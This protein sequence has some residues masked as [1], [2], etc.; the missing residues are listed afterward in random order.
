MFSEVDVPVPA[1]ALFGCAVPASA[2]S[3]LSRGMVRTS[4]P[5]MGNLTKMRLYDSWVRILPR[6]RKFSAPMLRILSTSIL[7]RLF[8]HMSLK[9]NVPK[10]QAF[11]F[12]IMHNAFLEAA[13]DDPHGGCWLGWGLSIFR[14]QT[15][16]ASNNVGRCTVAAGFGGLPFVLSFYG[17]SKPQGLTAM[18]FV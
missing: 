17:S 7:Q 15:V 16:S 5:W 6:H 10:R 18:I 13:T 12:P 2:S 8:L 14:S 3:S 9:F 1:S 4:E 11:S